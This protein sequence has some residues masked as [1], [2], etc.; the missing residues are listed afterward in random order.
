M[1]RPHRGGRLLR[2]GEDPLTWSLS[3]VLDPLARSFDNLQALHRARAALLASGF[4]PGVV[5]TRVIQDE[6]GPVEGDFG[7]GNTAHGG[8]SG[9]VLAGP[10][11]PYEE[12]FHRTATRGVHLLIVHSTDAA[13]RE[14][15][16]RALEHYGGVD[17]QARAARPAVSGSSH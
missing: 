13:A 17:P 1:Q 8:E 6:A 4:T 15:A 12:N 16:T 11:V 7:N 14:R 3:M 5:Q 10:E 2:Q 9:P